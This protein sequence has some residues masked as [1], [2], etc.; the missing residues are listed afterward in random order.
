MENIHLTIAT[1]TF[2]RAYILNQCYESLLAQSCKD[3]IWLIIDDGSNDNT[4]SLVR[5]WINERK[6]KIEY[7]KKSNGGKASALNVAL[8]RTDTEYFCCLDSDDYFFND[9][10][11]NAL[12]ELEE[13]ANNEKLAGILALRNEP[14]GKAMGDKEIPI[15]VKELTLSELN[16]KYRIYSEI[17]CFY[18]SKIIKEYRFPYIENEKFISPAYLDHEISRKYKF[19]ASS[20]KYCVCEYLEDGLTKNKVDTI[21]KNPKGYTLIKRQSFELSNKPKYKIKNGIMYIA[22]SLLSK[23]DGIITNSPHK[24]LTVL[25]FPVGWLAAKVRFK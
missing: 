25:L 13:I 24:I 21:K 4:E 16:S 12:A 5:D 14:D 7:I 1:P 2:N 8:D 23:S 15:S 3:F 11:E 20:L 18:K 17:I 6:I 10:V 9:A 19:K 22:G